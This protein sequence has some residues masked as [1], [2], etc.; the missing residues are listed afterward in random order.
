LSAPIEGQPAAVRALVRALTRGRVHHAWILHGPFGTGKFT[1]AMRLARLLLDPGATPEQRRTFTPP[2]TGE[3]AALIDA[4]THP[5]LHVVRKELAASSRVRELRER[6]QTNIP[7]ELVR[8]HM[9][10]GGEAGASSTPPVYRTPLLGHGKVFIVDEAELL[11]AESQNAMLKTLEEP[12]ER[13]WILLCTEHEE[14]LIPTVRSRCQRLPFGPL[15]ADAMS[16]W[17]SRSGLTADANAKAWIERFACGSPGLATIAVRE[18]LHEVWRSIEPALESTEKGRFDP[19]LGERLASFVD[20]YAKRVVKDDEHASKEAA[21]RA[22][23]RLLGAMLGSRVR[24][25]LAETADR[26]SAAE[27][28][29][30]TARAIHDVDDGQRANINLKHLLGNLVA[31]WGVE[32]TA[33]AAE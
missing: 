24:T 32:R 22:G 4:G 28:W 23:M 11:D 7:L 17:W 20:E 21:N 25:M 12:P 6:K 31:Q 9:L 27:R 19:T 2:T 13:T 10:G 15:S 29:L 14:R 3:V 1:V 30:E 18:N 26:R 33:G 16:R 8:E 5:D